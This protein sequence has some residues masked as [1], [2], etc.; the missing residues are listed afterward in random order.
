MAPISVNINL[1]SKQMLE[2]MASTERIRF[3][4]DEVEKGKVLVLERGLT[5]TEQTKL[6]ELT[7]AEIKQDEFIG[8][9]MQSYSAEKE[10]PFAKFIPAL[11]NR[12]RMA[13]IGPAS[14]LKTIHKDNQ[15]IQT[16]IL[17]NE[18]IVTPGA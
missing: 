12:P 18:G 6:I 17:T 10:S 8:I 1:V 13:V 9:E 16:Q 4:L 11:R 3:I 7:M 2:Q 5:A 15:Q 14:R